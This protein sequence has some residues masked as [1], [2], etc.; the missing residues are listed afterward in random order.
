MRFRDPSRL[1]QQIESHNEGYENAQLSADNSY[2]SAGGGGGVNSPSSV[3]GQNGAV[4]RDSNASYYGLEDPPKHKFTASTQEI[5]G[6]HDN[7]TGCC[8]LM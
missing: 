5:V 1:N 8:V 7:N 6:G 4:R 3:N 2:H